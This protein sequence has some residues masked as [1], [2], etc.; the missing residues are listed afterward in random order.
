MVKYSIG[1]EKCAKEITKINPVNKATSK[2]SRVPTTSAN[3][4]QLVDK[5]RNKWWSNID[6]AIT[7]HYLGE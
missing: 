2:K 4:V 3:D 1:N 7:T 5:K 6:I